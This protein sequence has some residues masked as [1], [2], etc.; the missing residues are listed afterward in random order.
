[1][2]VIDRPGFRIYRGSSPADL[3]AVVALD[4]PALNRYVFDTLEPGQ[5]YF[6]MTAI[7]SRGLE[8]ELSKVV[9]VTLQ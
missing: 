6:A 8:S 5:H 3:T 9:G 4:T 1:M 2:T 7:N